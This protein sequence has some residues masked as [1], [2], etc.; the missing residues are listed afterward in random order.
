MLTM[1]AIART[2]TACGQRGYTLP[3][4]CTFA[5]MTRALYHGCKSQHIGCP[6]TGQPYIGSTRF[7]SSISGRSKPIP[8]LEKTQGC[9]VNAMG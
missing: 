8:E 7:A 9:K 1:R 4:A 3:T 2:G 6:Y 5:H